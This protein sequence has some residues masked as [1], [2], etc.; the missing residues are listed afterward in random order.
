MFNIFISQTND[1]YLDLKLLKVMKITIHS[2]RMCI[3]NPQ[4]IKYK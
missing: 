3:G 4:I 2:E 1:Q